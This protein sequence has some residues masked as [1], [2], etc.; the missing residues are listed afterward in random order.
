MTSAKQ[1]IQRIIG[2]LEAQGWT[3]TQGRKSTHWKCVAPG[4]AG[5]VFMPST[6]SDTR[7]L[8]NTVG[9]LRRL[10]AKV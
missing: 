8:K 6:P 1:E 3:V 9:H 4:G 7:S 2:L 10:G 5:I